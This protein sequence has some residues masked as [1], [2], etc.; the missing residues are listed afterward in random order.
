MVVADS[1]AACSIS[2]R[3]SRPVAEGQDAIDV[4]SA[5]FFPHSISRYFRR[6]EMH[7]DGLIAPG[8]F[9]LMA[10]VGDVDELQAEFA[11]SVFEAASLVSQFRRE[12][13]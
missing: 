4:F 10:T 8:I 2:S 9:Q 12:E 1:Q 6:F 5:N 7:G 3:D 13:K 11:G